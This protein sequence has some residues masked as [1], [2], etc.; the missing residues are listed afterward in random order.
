MSLTPTESLVLEVV[1]GLVEKPPNAEDIEWDDSGERWVRIPAQA[2]CDLLLSQLFTSCTVTKSLAALKGL[3]DKGYLL[4][5]QRL[6]EWK[7][8]ASYLYRLPNAPEDE[9]E[10]EPLLLEITPEIASDLL[11]IFQYMPESKEEPTLEET[12]AIIVSN[13]RV[14]LEYAGT[15]VLSKEEAERVINAR[16]QFL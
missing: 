3:V 4:R 11:V 15:Q 12:L 8:L 14:Q 7:Y 5:V 2:V 10:D 1:V 16:E 9:P 13:F 6:G